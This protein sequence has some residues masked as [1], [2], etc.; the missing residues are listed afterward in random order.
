MKELVSIQNNCF[1]KSSPGAGQLFSYDGELDEG[2][3]R[4]SKTR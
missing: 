2:M 4:G 1:D 3:L